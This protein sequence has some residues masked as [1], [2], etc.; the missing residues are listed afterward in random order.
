MA[1]RYVASCDCCGWRQQTASKT[2]KLAGRAYRAH[3]CDKH[4]RRLEAAARAAA[5]EAAID[6]TPKP[7]LHKKAKHQHATHACY[8]LDR[9]RCLTCS[10]ANATY[11]SNRKRQAAYGRWAPFVDADTA[12][13]YVQALLAQGMGL[14]RIAV[15]SGVPHGALSR[16]IYGKRRDDGTRVPSA[17]IRPQTEAKLL[18]TQVDLAPGARVPA[19][20]TIRRLQ[21]LV[22]LGYSMNSL[23]RRLGCEPSNFTG[24][25]HGRVETT[26]ATADTVRG[27][28]DQLS[29]TLPVASDHR[30]RISVNRARNYAKAHGWL[31]P[32]AWDDDAIDQPGADPQSSLAAASSD[33]DEAADSGGADDLQHY[34]DEAAI[35]RRIYGDK[36][37]RLTPA[38]AA[39]VITRMQASD[40]SLA[41]IERHT[42][43]NS[44]RYLR[45]Y[46]T[47]S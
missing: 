35:E 7:C 5:R 33:L 45:R 44:H 20:G 47:A 13:R 21:A 4:R 22:A 18:R 34:L 3:S 46:R 2:E 38:E 29:M 42:G 32:L 41:A 27:I 43:L 23:A 19:L 25:I 30:S 15:V 26:R 14:K 11:E 31:P 39:A 17:R 1:T 36:S 24:L 8:V 37:V 6:R 10:A 16:L 9:C 40:W 12:R 28:Y